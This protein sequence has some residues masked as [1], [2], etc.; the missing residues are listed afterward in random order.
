MVADFTFARARH[1]MVKW[2]DKSYYNCYNKVTHKSFMH[3]ILLAKIRQNGEYKFSIGKHCYLYWSGKTKEKA[4]NALE[5]P[6]ETGCASF[7]TLIS[8]T[9][10]GKLSRS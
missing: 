10:K 2:T 9:G 3:T 1:V 4:G 7:K 6:R 5:K 8:K